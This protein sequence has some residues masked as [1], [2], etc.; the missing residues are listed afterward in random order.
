MEIELY[1]FFGF[2]RSWSPFPFFDG[3]NRGFCQQRTAAQHLSELHFSVGRNYDFHLDGSPHLHL[4]GEFWIH[5]DH[6]AHYL[7][8]CFRLFLSKRKGWGE[9]DH[10]QGKRS[11]D[12]E[13]GRI[14][15]HRGLVHHG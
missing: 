2:L 14:G 6:F 7:P 8:R 13:G 9:D 11:E 5:R 4:A 10:S 3:I 12:A 15:S 1:E